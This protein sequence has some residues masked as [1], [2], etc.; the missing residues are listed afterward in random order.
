[1]KI[2][3]LGENNS[4]HIQKWVK[5]IAMQ[6]DVQ[7]H[8]ISFS[9]GPEIEGVN[10][11]AL[12]KIT[13]TR[14][15]YMLNLFRVKKLI[16][17]IAPNI[18]HAH[19]ATSYGLLGAFS[20][21]HPFVITGWGADIFDSPSNPFMKRIL[22]FSFSKADAVTVLSQITKTEIG[23]LT[24]K[25]VDL[26]PFGVDIN[27][28]KPDETVTSKKSELIIGTIRTLKE[29]YG[30]EYLVKAFLALEEKFPNASLHIVGDGDQRTMLEELA[31]TSK[32]KNAIVF[33]GFVSQTKEPERYLSILRSFDIFVIP[34]VIDSETFGVA[35][36]EAAACAIPVVASCVGGLTEVVK[37]NETGIIVSPRN[38][39]ELSA[40]LEILLNDEIKRKQFGNNGRKNAEQL[41][42]WKNNVATMMNIYRRTI[43]EY[44]N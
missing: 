30:V 12:K 41:Y 5:A 35:A 43:E 15:D 44:K 29:K 40:A 8:V 32:Q 20:G 1:M 27:Y 3:L 14:F 4:V 37:D 6:Q 22:Q 38:V 34:S 39:K 28:F 33:H 42:N 18:I 21:F 16:Q 13:G 19:Y 7:L 24:N 25:P 31:A 2:V 10:Y 26:V 17:K 36:V 23:K 11:Y 9:G